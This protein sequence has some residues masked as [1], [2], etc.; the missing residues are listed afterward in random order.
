MVSCLNQQYYIK[1][2]VLDASGPAL[3]NNINQ[4]SYM[5]AGYVLS[6]GTSL[7]YIKI[8]WYDTAGPASKKNLCQLI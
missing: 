5:Y 6:Q 3:R 1:V 7:C 4:G 8:G 2:T